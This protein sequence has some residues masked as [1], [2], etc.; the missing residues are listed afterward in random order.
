M[1]ISIIYMCILVMY[2]LT[3]K[4]VVWFFIYLQSFWNLL[5]RQ[6][7]VGRFSAGLTEASYLAVLLSGKD[8][9]CL[10]S[11]LLYFSWNAGTDDDLYLTILCP[12]QLQR[13]IVAHKIYKGCSSWIKK[14][15]TSH[16]WQCNKC[17]KKFKVWQKTSRSNRNCN[18]VGPIVLQS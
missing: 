7:E 14:A 18:S 15:A 4:L 10:F 13:N 17:R 9:K 8:L 2:C 16:K 12:Y 6:T 5:D 1:F 11:L 3:L